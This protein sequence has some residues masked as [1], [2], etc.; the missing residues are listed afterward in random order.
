MHTPKIALQPPS[1]ASKAPGLS[2]LRS[3]QADSGF[4]QVLNLV[5]TPVEEVQ[6]REMDD[7]SERKINEN[8][9]SQDQ[10][11]ESRTHD[12]HDHKKVNERSD[13]VQPSDQYADI[14]QEKAVSG[15]EQNQILRVVGQLSQDDL[16]RL[17]QWQQGQGELDPQSEL[18]FKFDQLPELKSVPTS[19][20]MAL[21]NGFNQAQLPENGH[22]L[23]EG[24]GQFQ[25]NEAQLLQANQ[26]ASQQFIQ[27]FQAL[28]NVQNQ[29]QVNQGAVQNGG[30]EWVARPQDVMPALNLLKLSNA[31]KEGIVKQVAHGFK[32]QGGTTQVTEIRLHPEELGA[33]RLKIEVQGQDVRLFFSAE[34]A[35]V[36]DLISQNMDQLKALLFEQDFNLAEAGLFQDQLQ[37][38][39]QQESAAQDEGED[40]GN[41]DRPDLQKRPKSGPRMSP[42]PGRFRATV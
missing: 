1:V 38:Q 31:Q 33:V 21:L 4:D 23:L 8:R 3:N 41:D 17:V 18:A 42:L 28:Q 40:Y 9:E 6:P 22:A 34:N 35:A 27:D 32:T 14:E 7:L 10:V 29:L 2:S 39:D 11:S 5:N 36:Q 24:V 37:G 20:L 12:Q 15:E 13:E 16:L 26:G 25:L 19:D 30:M